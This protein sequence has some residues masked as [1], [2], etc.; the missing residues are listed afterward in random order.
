MRPPVRLLL[1][2]VL[3]ASP[4]AAQVVPYPLQNQ[5]FLTTG[6]I[7]RYEMDRIRAQSNESQAL[8]QSQARQTQMTV[9]TL[10]AQRQPPLVLT[11]PVQAL[12][13]EQARR[14]RQA[15]Q[16]RTT[17]ASQA[18]SQIDNWLDRRAQ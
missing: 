6:D 14:E 5:P 11:P 8:A 10:Q 18:T 15:T 4:V 1:V 2:L 9:Q 3:S 12:T 16:A 7:H 13:L 17:A